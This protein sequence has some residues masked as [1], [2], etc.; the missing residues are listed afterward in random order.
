MADHVKLS[1]LHIALMRAG[2]DA[3]YPVLNLQPAA[4]LRRAAM[5]MQ[6]L[7]EQACNGVMRWDDKARRMLPSWDDSDESRNVAAT[8]RAREKAT[9]AIAGIFGPNWFQAFE[10]EFQRDPRG[11]PI[12]IH[13]KGG[14]RGWSPLVAVY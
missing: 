12:K 6:S 10:L 4:D 7:N 11:A 14:N 3:G 9:I 1:D 5:R 2:K 13:D 8:E